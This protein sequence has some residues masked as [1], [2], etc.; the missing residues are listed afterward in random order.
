MTDGLFSAVEVNDQLGDRLPGTRLQRTEVWNW[1]TF[2]DRV[3]ALDL[4]GR[5][6]LLTG[7]IGSG[8]STLVDALTTLLLPAHKIAY[9]KAS[10]A[11]TRERDLRSYVLGFYKSERNETTGA[12]KPVALRGVRDYSVLL[13]VFHN[14]DFNTTVTLAQVFW[15]RDVNA[16]QPVRFFVVADGSLSIAEH[17][18]D[19]GPDPAQLR[20]RLR[21]Q[22]A[23]VFD[24]FPDYGK[25]FRRRLGIDTEQAMELF[26]QTVSMKAVDNL[27]GF[28]RQHMLEPFDVRARLDAL[29]G[30]FEDLVRAHEAVLR[31]RAQL[32][33]LQP[34]IGDL[35]EHAA[36]S[37]QLSDLIAQ[38]DALPF[39]L[40]DRRRGLLEVELVAIDEQVRGLEADRQRAEA[41][42]DRL[43]EA[44]M[45]LGRQI[46]GHG[47]DR[48]EALA[49]EIERLEQQRDDRRQ[50][51][52]RLNELLVAARLDRIDDVAELPRAHRDA[53]AATAQTEL[54]Q[55]EAQN[56]LTE[57]RVGL[58]DVGQEKDDIEAELRSLQGRTSNLP[59][60]VVRVRDA[61]CRDLGR[62]ADDLPFAGELIQV[63][64]DRQEWEGAAERVLRGFG[65][66][67]LVPNGAY[68]A[69]RRWVDARHLGTKIVYFRVPERVAPRPSRAR[70]PGLHLVDC[71]EIA[72]DAAYAAW[73]RAELERRADHRCVEDVTGF[74]IA[75]RAVTRA[76]QVKDVD[77]H[78]KDDRRRVDDRRFFV[79][80]WSNQAKIDVLLDEVGRLKRRLD[81]AVAK[82]DQGQQTLRSLE[83]R[84]AALTG[85]REYRQGTDLDWR[86]SVR[87]IAAAE[88]DQREIEA[89]SDVLR[90]LAAQR[91]ATRAK[92]RASDEIRAGLERDLGK[93]ETLRDQAQ[94]ALA[95]IAAMLADRPE[96]PSARGWFEAIAERAA[97]A[98]AG[99]RTAAEVERM[100][101]GLT[102]DW[103]RRI[104]QLGSRRHGTE[105]RAIKK[106]AEFRAAH[107]AETAEL[108]DS[109]GSGRE[110]RNLHERV[111][112]DDL[113]R[114]E[115]Q[116]KE[117]LNTNTINDIATFA[118]QLNKQR[119]LIQSRVAS[120]NDSLT[121]I[122]Y[123]RDRYIRLLAER[124][125]NTEIRDFQNDLRACTD[126]VI[127]VA[128]EQYSEQR[129]L[130]VKRLVDRFK[131]REGLVEA[132][133]AW[134]RRV[135]D[136]R[137][138]FVF[139]ASERWRH[140]DSEHESYTDSGGKSG[141]QKEKLAYTILAASLAYQFRLDWGVGQ[142]RA[143]RFVVIDEAFS[144]GSEESTR[145]ALRL[146]TELGLQ[147][148]IV[149]PLQ[150]I[151][152]IEP[153]VS[154]V[155]FVDNPSGA[156]SRLQ[157]LTI[158]E[159]RRSLAEHRAGGRTSGAVP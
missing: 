139:S 144:R 20:K 66:S 101:A 69:V 86:L 153:H 103:T 32:D 147:L 8:K 105:Q 114:F 97:D 123:N 60:Q 154:T 47:G 53:D 70:E 28:V 137:N 117:Y 3:W 80:G 133:R 35:D 115:V 94:A 58:R 56:A 121:A 156:R 34:L 96:D 127:G 41:E 30:H 155:G 108:D 79:L 21:A 134:T 152:V 54:A 111:R 110:Y 122:D 148:M 87:Q 145:Y 83:A 129:F 39:F 77:R 73:L 130:Q 93:I 95:E 81:A 9:N 16:G 126:H 42:C 82:V 143:F 149:T 128:A 13:G 44:E 63:A 1:G 119:E 22:G 89:S 90:A 64:A 55:A 136:V 88:A 15:S 85:L 59:E 98:L 159:F 131:G 91:E 113:P 12:T 50:R 75:R 37:R 125:P 7:D 4:G 158:T 124:S 45:D 104:E 36:L 46:S 29:V 10:G 142:S 140:D 120:I 27:N 26:G 109:L 52:A 51:F 146:F 92:L 5:N 57:L 61:L 118:A 2:G 65:L 18:S 135:T 132:D 84:R 6:T 48:I 67:L 24:G 62:S 116:F 102:Q 71:L 100:A 99:V 19:F 107:P 17:F 43:R 68:D 78:E 23:E 25:A 72:E 106:M 76:G 138:W 14:A 157:G 31:A 151:H 40:A 11:D 74:A 112:R 49:R 38:R 141:G 150:K 33:M